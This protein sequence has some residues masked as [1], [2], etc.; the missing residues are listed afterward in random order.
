MARA[1]ARA[2]RVSEKMDL[3]AAARTAAVVETLD[4]I[5][6]AMVDDFLQARAAVRAAD[7]PAAEWNALPAQQRK[8]IELDQRRHKEL[9]DGW[10]EGAISPLALRKTLVEYYA[11]LGKARLDAR[12]FPEQ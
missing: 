6:N 2:N 12:F 11:R 8:R 3:E 7:W 1:L 4:Q 9:V 5:A 10:I